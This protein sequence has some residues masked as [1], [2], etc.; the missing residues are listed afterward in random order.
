MNLKQ[1]SRKIL[2]MLIL[3]IFLLVAVIGSLQ[4]L[5]NQIERISV[6]STG[7]DANGASNYASISADGRFVAFWSQAHNLVSGDSGGGGIFVRDRE[8][9]INE[10]VSI[11]STG[12]NAQGNTMFPAI[13]ANNRFVAF[14][15]NAS[16]LVS[17]DTNGVWDIF[18]R[19]RQMGITE[20]VSI[21]SLG[22]QGNGNSN[23]ASVSEDGRFVAF[24]SYASNL[25]MGDN[26]DT[27]DIFVHDRLNDITERVNLSSTE[28]Q[29]EPYSSFDPS[30][31][32]DGRFVAFRSLA[33]N[34]VLGDT[35][36]KWDIFVRDRQAGTTQRVSINN[37]N[38]QAN[39]D[40]IDSAI[41]SDGNFVVFASTA[42][43]L[44]SGDANDL[45]DLFVRDRQ[46]GITERIEVFGEGGGQADYSGLDPCISGDGRFIAF[47][48]YGLDSLVPGDTNNA[49]DIF[50]YDRQTETNKRVNLSS[51]GVQ[52]NYVSNLASISG[53]G[54]F[55][56]FSSLADNLVANDTIGQR[57][58][59]VTVNAHN[60][61]YTPADSTVT[62]L[63][64]EHRLINNPAVWSQIGQHTIDG[65]LVRINVSV[66]NPISSQQIY[67]VQFTDGQ[68]GTLLR[69]YN[70]TTNI[71]LP[72]STATLVA[73]PGNND[74]A[75][76]WDTSGYAWNDDHTKHSERQVRAT[77]KFNSSEINTKTSLV[78]IAPKPIIFVHGWNSDAATWEDFED[79]V[80]N[81][82]DEWQTFAVD[83]M[84]T[85]Q[86][87][88][89]NKSLPEN[90][91][92]LEAYVRKIR[93]QTGAEQVDLVAHSFG[94]LI[95]RYYIQ[96][97]MGEN[98][99][100]VRA[101]PFVSHLMMLGTPNWGSPC[102]F[103]LVT[104]G[105]WRPIS[106]EM[107]PY[108]A[109]GFN[110]IVQN[111]RDVPFYILAGEFFHDFTCTSLNPGDGVVETISAVTGI[112]PAC[113]IIVPERTHLGMTNGQDFLTHIK[114]I[115]ALG[116]IAAVQPPGCGASS[117]NSFNTPPPAHEELVWSVVRTLNIP[118]GATTS[119][120]IPVM[121]GYALGVQISISPVI[122]TVLD[123]TNVIQS[124]IDNSSDQFDLPV[125]T[126]RIGN[127]AV[128]M[129][130]V[131][132]T[133]PASSTAM[134][135]VVAYLRGD[136]VEFKLD[137]GGSSSPMQ[138]LQ[139]DPVLRPLVATLT[140][141]AVPI[142][143]ATVMAEFMDYGGRKTTKSLT[144]QGNGVYGL[145][146][147]NLV[148]GTYWVNLTATTPNW[149][150]TLV[151]IWI[152][153]ADIGP[154][155]SYYTTTTPTLTWNRLTW[156]LSYEIQVDE[157][158][159]FASP[160]DYSSSVNGLQDTTTPISHGV[161]YWR[162]R[163]CSLPNVCG[164]WSNPERFEV[165]LNG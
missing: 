9:G 161:H 110:R 48:T 14:A 42:S 134:V 148:P 151:T 88:T 106:G 83:T 112:D 153:E 103:K 138:A 141:N 77:L 118:A 10:R 157:T 44:V 132:I 97:Y 58:V 98:T 119:V 53:D 92:A 32:G 69:V 84:V 86:I 39:D 117:T 26:N 29:T 160:L 75:V 162:V 45:Y 15:S 52:A 89:M 6:S 125:R 65:N 55:V 87:Y 40:S 102:A 152:V 35:N 82:N 13:S 159:D 105:V 78:K 80:T 19:D 128:G 8:N 4:A 136:P 25:V 68:N 146:N 76:L 62:S 17:G 59:F 107:L 71:Q 100:P 24:D 18:V 111:Q 46:G 163:G 113:R 114:P 158:E 122:S 126:H 37:S 56:A 93:I 50:V 145:Q 121:G 95:S 137:S 155:L 7:G 156:A 154:T 31:S 5:S 109:R 129:W 34:L 67:E 96:N 135:G 11:S 61:V 164:P 90:A 54:R 123:P 28:A 2:I 49:A 147:P 79:Q 51:A 142:T 38:V 140:E 133:N 104:L 72:G 101:K 150:R 47:S 66:Q 23:H 130:K 21:S 144:H 81:Y 91:Q 124:T 120:D 85:N 27:Y 33:P 108:F 1:H 57:D 94:G 41:S 99:F 12:V 131:Q 63:S 22:A 30:I 127:P 116:P 60:A 3:A 43:N 36:L 16:N 20:R 73:Q 70:S 143:D 165:D 139:L 74:F 149:T 64:F 115:L